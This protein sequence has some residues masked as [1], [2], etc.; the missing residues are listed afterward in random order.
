MTKFVNIHLSLIFRQ[1]EIILFEITVGSCL[2]SN[3][4]LK[5]TRSVES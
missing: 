4:T 2:L 5:V 3:D 1:T